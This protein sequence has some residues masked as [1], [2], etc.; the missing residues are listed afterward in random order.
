MNKAPLE[1][2]I[3]NARAIALSFDAP[4]DARSFLVKLI[5]HCFDE[6]D[7]EMY[8]ALLEL[9]DELLCRPD[10]FHTVWRRNEAAVERS[11]ARSLLF[12]LVE[13]GPHF[14]IKADGTFIQHRDLVTGQKLD[15]PIV[16]EA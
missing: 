10:G 1:E 12:D 7:D 6:M 5:N 4:L 14:E 8:Q 15:S 2:R 16:R 3:Q 13:K 9:E 11:M